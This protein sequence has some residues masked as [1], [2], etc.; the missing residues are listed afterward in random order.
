MSCLVCADAS[1]PGLPP[2]FIKKMSEVEKPGAPSGSG[3]K[4]TRLNQPRRGTCLK[5][6]RNMA[7]RR[8]LRRLSFIGGGLNFGWDAASLHFLL[9]NMCA[10]TFV[11]WGSTPGADDRLS[12]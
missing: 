4:R 9:S 5:H 6:R 7:D 1:L 10:R 3:V 8:V 12:V 2:S 11:Q